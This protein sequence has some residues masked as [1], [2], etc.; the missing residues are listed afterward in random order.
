M[1]CKHDM[2]DIT[3]LINMVRRQTDYT[4]DVIKEKLQNCNNDPM[5][6]IMEFHGI[7]L[8]AKKK[9]E[10]EKL[11]SNQKTFKAIRDFF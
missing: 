9:A 8:E 7:D 10:D 5:K 1:D 6:V 4:E 2:N 3:Q 11:T